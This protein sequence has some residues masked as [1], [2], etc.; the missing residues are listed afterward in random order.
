MSNHHPLSP[1]K[2]DMWV[3]CVGA[4]KMW[5]HS[6]ALFSNSANSGTAAHKMLEQCLK[7]GIKP[8]FFEGGVFEV[9]GEEI[10]VDEDMI[11]A[12]NLC[13]CIVKNHVTTWYAA[14]LYIPIP[15]IES[16]YYGNNNFVCY[17]AAARKLI[18]L[19]FKYGRNSVAA[20]GNI[21]LLLYAIGTLSLETVGEVD[22]IELVIVQP[23]DY[24]KK[25]KSVF[26]TPA[27]LT[28]WLNKLKMRKQKL[29]HNCRP[30]LR[31]EEVSIRTH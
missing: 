11:E 5:E 25:V 30:T 15:K 21:Q 26:I 22:T 28:K 7:I 27:D 23:R 2:A 18:I 17:N 12:L 9:D 16:G 10:E 14:E 8:E 3:N 13:L 29:H 19:D 24:V 31:I 6:P 4:P 20:E 1:S